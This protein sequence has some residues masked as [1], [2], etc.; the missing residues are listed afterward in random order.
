[1]F[2]LFKL[3]HVFRTSGVLVVTRTATVEMTLKCVCLLMVSVQLRAVHTASLEL[4]VMKVRIINRN[5]ITKDK[6]NI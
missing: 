3:Q 1:M 2:I 6:M 5:R 4:A